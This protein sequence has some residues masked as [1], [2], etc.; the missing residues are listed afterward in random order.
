MLFCTH[1]M[2][3]PFFCRPIPTY[4]VL[5]YSM[6]HTHSV[7]SCRLIST[8]NVISAHDCTWIVMQELLFGVARTKVCLGTKETG[9][10]LKITYTA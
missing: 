5:P 7:Y 4:G 1:L 10:K 3:K 9:N 8:W 2:G 6:I